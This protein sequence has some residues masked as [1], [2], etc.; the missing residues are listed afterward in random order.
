MTELITDQ[1]LLQ[2]YLEHGSEAAFRALVDRYVNLVFGTARRR[3]SD[4]DAAR[5]VT[6]EVF[7]ALARR[8]A[9]LRGKASVA[10]WLHRTTLLETKQ[11]WRSTLRRQRRE[12]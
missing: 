3:L 12:H 4:D 10:G 9:W 6:Q 5:D 1:R 2:E 7:A 11:W 8:A